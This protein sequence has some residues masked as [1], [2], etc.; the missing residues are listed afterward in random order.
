M[1]HPRNRRIGYAVLAV[2]LA[3]LCLFPQPFVAR[4]KILPQDT[5]STGLNAVLNSIAGQD[6]VFSAF[7]TNRQAIDIY[8]IIARSR[9]VRS[10]VVEN[11]GLVGPGKRYMSVGSAMTDIEDKVEINTMTG[12]VIQI[13]TTTH[14]RS[15]AEQLTA[16][17]SEAISDR[18]R[19]LGRDQLAIKQTIV[20][21]RFEEATRRVAETETA[22]ND[23][24]RRTG[25]TANP[26]AELGTAISQRAGLEAA[27]E[28]K[29]VEFATQRRFAGPENFELRAIQQEMI[30]LRRQLASTARVSAGPGN[31]SATTLSEQSNQYLTLLRDYRYAQALYEIYARFAE[32]AAVEEL[33]SNGDSVQ[34]VEASHLDSGRQFNLAAVALLIFLALVVFVTELYAPAT[35]LIRKSEARSS[36]D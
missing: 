31:P 15:E 1:K 22:L 25:F 35:G 19:S 28:A 3:V 12:G 11:L 10:Q 34:I 21:D 29:Q 17:F 36:E 30:E 33:S 13:L 23:F 6:G 5:S 14:D 4:A 26:D 8:L 18:I 9:E 32:Q 2:I 7:L 27:L 16:A 24:R 20:R